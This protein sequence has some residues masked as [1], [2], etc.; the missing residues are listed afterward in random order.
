MRKKP[1]THVWVIGESCGVESVFIHADFKQH[2]V[3][4]LRA[5]GGSVYDQFVSSLEIC[6]KSLIASLKLGNRIFLHIAVTASEI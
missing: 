6:A 1:I 4:I 2:V 5:V 3:E